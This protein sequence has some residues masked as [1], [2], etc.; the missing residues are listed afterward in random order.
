MLPPSLVPTQAP[1]HPR[2]HV[3]HDEVPTAG[4]APLL[5]TPVLHAL[6]DRRL[7]V[8]QY[9]PEADGREI[10]RVARYA[11]MTD[12]SLVLRADGT[13]DDRWWR[14]FSTPRA[15]RVYRRRRWYR[16][17]GHAMA[18]GQYGWRQAMDA[19]ARRYP[20]IV[21]DD[22]DIFVVLTLALHVDERSSIPVPE[23]ASA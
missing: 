13:D 9:V 15:A 2:L 19:Y 12:G 14:A 10:T 17:Y 11:V 7:C 1:V 5:R 21:L 3:R 8:L 4:I 20:R 16:G 18:H 22:A 23:A 6:A